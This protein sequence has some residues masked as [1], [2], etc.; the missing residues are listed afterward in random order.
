M[1]QIR[2][3][4]THLKSGRQ[5][6]EQFDTDGQTNQC[7]HGTMGDGGGE[8]DVHTAFL[9]VNLN[10]QT[11]HEAGTETLLLLSLVHGY[12]YTFPENVDC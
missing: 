6:S 2:S 8:V 4:K 11:L 10:K 3:H 7:G 12:T 9:I 5:G 1:I